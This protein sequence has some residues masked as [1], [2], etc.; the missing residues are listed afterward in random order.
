MRMEDTPE[1][2]TNH[3]QTN[4]T[5]YRPSLGGISTSQLKLWTLHEI[6]KDYSEITIQDDLE[7]VLGL[8]V[9]RDRSA[10]TITLK[11]EG[12]IHNCLNAHFP[13]WRSISMDE[14]PQRPLPSMPPRMSKSDMLLDEIALSDGKKTLYQRKIGELV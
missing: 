5:K 11:Q 14:L 7:T 10:K 9:S 1:P 4:S 8:E 3:H 6:R 2:F 12:S 13:E